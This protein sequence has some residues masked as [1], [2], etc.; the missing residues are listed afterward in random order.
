MAPVGINAPAREKKPEAEALYED[1]EMSGSM[2]RQR[3]AKPKEAAPPKP[4]PAEEKTD[5]E[6]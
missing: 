4:K 2:T 3:S 6:A 5:S 1:D